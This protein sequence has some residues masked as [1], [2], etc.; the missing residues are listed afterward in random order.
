MNTKNLATRIIFVLW[1]VPVSWLIAC[2]DFP[3]ENYLNFLLPPDLQLSHIRP[4]HLLCIA[5]VA[6]ALKEYFSMLKR[7][8]PRNGFW[9][10]GVWFAF[11]TLLYFIS[12]KIIP[13]KIDIY[14]LMLIVA[15]EAFI[16]GRNTGRWK[17]ASLLLSGTVFLYIAFATCADFYSPV[18]QGVFDRNS[19]HML[20]SQLGIVT[21]LMAIFLCD[22]MAFFAGSLF[23]KHHFSSISPKKTLEG[24]A[25]GFIAAIVTMTAGWYFFADA[26]YPLW[27]GVLLGVFIG[28]FAQLGDLT[29]SLMKR[30]FEVKDASDIIPGHGGV[31]D[32]F[33]SMFFTTPVV[34]LYMIILHKFIP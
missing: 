13:T 18:F 20:L 21:V 15:L 27:N 33:D 12:D 5:L 3:L 6:L 22:S 9:V 1:A 23:G 30:Y 2:Y 11:Q 34:A 16:W 19:D 14:I 7:L 25:A 26:K 31:L 29:V 28:I 17:R 32:R 10:A 24:A 8:Y 4:G